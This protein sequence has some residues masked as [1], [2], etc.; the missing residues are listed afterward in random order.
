MYNWQDPGSNPENSNLYSEHRQIL[1]YIQKKRLRIANCILWL[2]YSFEI[3]ISLNRHTLS[4]FSSAAVVHLNRQKCQNLFENLLTRRLR[5]QSRLSQFFPQTIILI[6]FGQN[7]GWSTRKIS[8]ELFKAF[9]CIA[10]NRSLPS[11]DLA[12]NAWKN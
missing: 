12:E 11:S 3:I 7:F 1:T 6:N 5:S 9:L 4:S 10:T 2:L 8:L